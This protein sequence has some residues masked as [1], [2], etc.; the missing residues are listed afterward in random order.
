[1][2]GPF[3][4]AKAFHDWM[5]AAATRQKPGD[6]GIIEGLDH[7]DMLRDWFPDDARIYLTHGDLTLQNI[8]VSGAPGSYR[9]EAILDWEQAGWYPEYWEH[10]KM[11]FG[12]GEDDEWTAQD[13]PG[14]IIEHDE[15]VYRAFMEYYLWRNGC[16]E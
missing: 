10:G 6:D 8:I 7:P 2:K 4:H 14:K 16:T 13:W 3:P 11:Y 5:F 9:I 15:D 12:A 1:M